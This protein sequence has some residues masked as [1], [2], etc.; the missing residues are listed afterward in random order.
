MRK[1]T[2]D[3]FEIARHNPPAG[4]KAN[5]V[6][7][8]YSIVGRRAD[9]APSRLPKV[10]LPASS[11]KITGPKIQKLATLSTLVKKQKPGAATLPPRPKIATLN[12]KELAKSAP[13]VSANTKKANRK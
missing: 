7:I 1:R 12:L 3:G 2:R 6:L 4:A 9:L 8:G 11:A 13:R 10:K 5:S